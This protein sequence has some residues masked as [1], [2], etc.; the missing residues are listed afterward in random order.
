[1]PVRLQR[2]EKGSEDI[3]HDGWVGMDTCDLLHMVARVVG[4]E[5]TKA[6]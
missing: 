2:S 4:I 5:I 1:M 3:F 6:R